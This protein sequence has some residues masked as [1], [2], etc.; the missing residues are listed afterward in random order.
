MRALVFHGPGAKRVG[1]TSEQRCHLVHPAGHVANIGVHGRPATLHHEEPWIK[2]VTITVGLVDTSP[3]PT[4]PDLVDTGRV[5]PVRF[6]THRFALDEAM[7]ACDTFS[8]PAET[9]AMRVAMT[10]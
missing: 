4:L 5:D 9:D 2:G 1:T 7:D 6:T 8:R 10:R 3:I